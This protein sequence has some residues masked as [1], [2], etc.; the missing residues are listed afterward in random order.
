LSA[1]DIKTKLKG[2]EHFAGVILLTELSNLKIFDASVG[3]ISNWDDH[4]FAIF[5]TKK[6]IEIFDSLGMVI[7]YTK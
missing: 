6:H 7:N 5:V 4:W 3:F 2:V 1:V